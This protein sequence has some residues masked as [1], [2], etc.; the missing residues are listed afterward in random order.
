MSLVRLSGPPQLCVS[1]QEL[2]E[3]LRLDAGDT[4]QDA[5]LAGHLRTAQDSIDGARGWLG[6]ALTSQQW[7]LTLDFF[8]W[9]GII[10]IPLPPLQTV[11]SLTYIDTDG[12]TQSIEDFLVYGAGG[13]RPARL[14]PAHGARW[15][16]ARCQGDA[17]SVVFTCGHDSFSDVPESVR[18]AVL[19]TAA[20][21]YDGC[22]HDDAIQSLL[23]P[24]RVW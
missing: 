18:Q 1:L 4:S 10:E 22:S 6:V 17:V 24:H 8:P 2:K 21:L 7:L 15:P 20:G 14:A 3:Q 11:D 5:M 13:S 12:V 9:H 16:A 23:T 19:L